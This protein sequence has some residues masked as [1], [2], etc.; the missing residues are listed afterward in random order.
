MPQKIKNKR[1]RVTRSD[2]HY[3][4]KQPQDK[5]S[6]YILSTLHFYILHF[7]TMLFLIIGLLIVI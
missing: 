5:N 2:S 4:A 7:F 3:S 6:F 1:E